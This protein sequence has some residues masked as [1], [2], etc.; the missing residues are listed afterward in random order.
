MPDGP[1][2]FPPPL[3]Y[4]AARF[5]PGEEA[6]FDGIDLPAEVARAVPKRRLEFLA[7]RHCAAVALRRLQP[8]LGEGAI[9]IGGDRAPLWPEGI[10][11]SIT[12]TRGFAAAVVARAV[13]AGGVGLDTE[14]LVSGS[15]RQA[16]EERVT[17]PEETGRLASA[18]LS[19]AALLTLVFSAKESLFKCLFPKVGRYFGFDAASIVEVSTD[20]RTF[21]A[22][23]CVALGRFAAGTR[24]AG[25]YTLESDLVHTGVIFPP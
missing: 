14:H 3:V 5:E 15:A 22:E 24:F 19:E 17:T 20:R 9:G 1:E 7:G 10:V 21:C 18:G 4:A 13:D 6:R 2:L 16:V 23:L 25:R 12:H 11:G 8:G